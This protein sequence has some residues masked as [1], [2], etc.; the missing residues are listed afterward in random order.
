MKKSTREL[1][2]FYQ[3]ME[4]NH[5]PLSFRQNLVEGI[6]VDVM[7]RMQNAKIVGVQNLVLGV[8]IAFQ[9]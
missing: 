2:K 7:V 8:T 9:C 3:E 6:V 4:I 1:S 5:V